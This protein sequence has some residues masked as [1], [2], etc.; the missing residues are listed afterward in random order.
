MRKVN[1]RPPVSFTGN[2]LFLFAVLTIAFSVESARI[3]ARG[4]R[5][6]KVFGSKENLRLNPYLFDGF[7]KKG[8]IGNRV[9]TPYGYSLL[10]QATSTADTVKVIALR[11]EFQ[12]DSSTL[13]TGNGLFGIYRETKGTR[14]D[15]TEW[16]W[17]QN[18]KYTYDNLPHDSLYF[19][20]QLEFVKKYFWNVSR[21]HFCLEYQIFPQGPSEAHAYQ[22]PQKMIYYS[23]GA[24][25]KEE[26]WDDYYSRRTLGLM[27][28]VRDAIM[29]ADTSGQSPFGNLHMDK[30]T[31]LIYETDPANPNY[32]R[33]VAI[34]LFHAGASYLTDGGWDGYFG[35]DSPSDMIDAFIST[36]FFS[37]FADTIDGIEKDPLLKSAGVR[38]NKNLPNEFIVNELMMVSETSNQDSLN[39]GIHGILVNQIA[40]QI[41]IPDLFSTMSGISGIGGFCIMDFAGYSSGRGFI[42][43]WPSAWVRA[44]MGWDR[45]YLYEPGAM[46]KSARLKSICTA[47]PTDTSILLV[48]INSHEYYLIENRQRNL[49]GDP[50]LFNY[51]TTSD[52]VFIDPYNPVNLPNNVVSLF[53]TSQVIDSVKN[54]DISLPASGVLVWHVDEYIIRDHMEQNVVNADSSYRGIS[55]EEAD[56]VVDLGVMFQDMFYQAAFDYGGAEDVFPHHTSKNAAVISSM[57]PF[58]LPSTQSNDG[59]HTYLKLDIAP[60]NNIS[61]ETCFLYMRGYYVYNTVDSVFHITLARD[62]TFVTSYA[63]WPK[64]VVPGVFFEPV[65]CDVYDNGDTSEIALLDTTGRLYLWQAT[66]SDSSFGMKKAAYPTLLYNF[67]TLFT[68]TVTYLEHIPSP[69]S[70]PTRVNKKL[71]LPSKDGNIYVLISV[72]SSHGALWDTIPLSTPPASYLCNFSGSQWAVGGSDGTV[73]F[74]DDTTSA[75][76]ATLQISGAAVQALAVLD[77]IEKTLAAVDHNGTVTVFSSSRIHASLNVASRNSSVPVFPPFTLVT[78]DLDQDGAADIV[79]CDKKQGL[80]LLTYNSATG[81]LQYHPEWIGFPNDW[82]SSYSLG[83]KRADLPD[84]PSAPS[85]ADCDGD[86]LLDIVVGGT[87]GIYACNYRGVQLLKFPAFLDKRYWYQRGTIVATPVIGKEPQTDNPLVIFSAPTGENITFS[88]AKVIST[89]L[90]TGTVYYKRPDGVLDSISGLTSSFIDSLLVLGDS[91]VL[92]YIIPGGHVDAITVNGQRPDSVT[93]DNTILSSWPFSVGGHIGCAPLLCD[94]DN[95]TK[96]DVIAVSDEGWV[97]RWEVS[98]QILP[99]SFVWAQ[100]G[101]NNARTFSYAGPALGKPK[102]GLSPSIDYFYSYPNPA[103]S[104]GSDPTRFKYLLNQPASSVRLDIFTYTGYHVYSNTN[105]PS[106]FGLNEWSIVPKDFGSAVYRCRLEADFNGVKKVKYW[107]MAVIK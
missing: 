99:N 24:K 10:H 18:K 29:Q 73:T 70:F 19:A 50:Q 34:L 61:Q 64:R 44:Y 87:N 9:R 83:K 12:L 60:V 82:A 39:W 15:R 51:D 63:D 36:E 20:H 42:P 57:S 48:P 105:L 58:T 26:T 65:L 3:N 37:Y 84:N 104:N 5:Q 98:P 78:G 47:S 76:V 69:V 7:S 93:S 13:T 33:K 41:G 54:L 75:T 92:P 80:W 59:G 67:D 72:D 71:F 55:L 94:L 89:D 2:A 77:T 27:K 85:L 88:V 100:A 14:E 43:P 53:P 62:T 17:Y 90:T 86:N 6:A 30:T 106:G 16:E 102:H 66:G 1:P 40:R 8:Y 35:Q 22:V 52:T 28:F 96:T 101:S 74:G 32:R 4:D 11:V 81:S 107:K 97:Y 68:D 56:G 23:P 45:P 79:L 49:T 46:S 38:V 103:P 25:K 91:L 95:N 21:G 31:G